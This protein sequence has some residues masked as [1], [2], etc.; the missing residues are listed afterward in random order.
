MYILI[1]KTT[2]QTDII[3]Y[4]NKQYGF[5]FSLPESWQGYQIVMDKWEGKAIDENAKIVESGPL[6]MIRHPEWTAEN[7]R[8]DIP[9]M[10]L[11]LGSGMRCKIMNL[12]LA[13]HLLD[14]VNWG[15][16]INMCLLCRRV[17]ILL[18]LPDMGG[19]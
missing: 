17:T 18:S 19:S 4:E 1:H 7:V 12:L 3:T 9:I 16:I 8:Q 5:I 14:R 2:P 15:G 11:L 13:R 6:L 10:I